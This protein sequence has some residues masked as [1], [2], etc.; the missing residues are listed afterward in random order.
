M[1]Y[2]QPLT[3]EKIDQILKK[4]NKVPYFSP[5]IYLCDNNS[6]RTSGRTTRLID[7]YI[8]VLFNNPNK[9]LWQMILEPNGFGE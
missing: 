4:S 9:E 5:Y 8:Q 3:Q 7:Y 6:D 1:F 2:D